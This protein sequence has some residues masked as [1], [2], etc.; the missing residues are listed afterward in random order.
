[1]D[2]RAAEITS[3]LKDQ[4]K[5]F[6][7]EAE[8]SEIGQVLSVGDGIARVYGLE[9]VMAGEL[10]EFPGQ[11]YGLVL[12][13][14]QDNVGVAVLG[15]A[16]AVKE[17]DTVKRTGRIAEVPVGDAVA[18]RV[19]NALCARERGEITAQ[20][21][22]ASRLNAAQTSALKASLKSSFGK[23]VRIDANVD[24]SLLGGLIVKVG[25]RMIDT[26]LRTRLNNLKFAMKEVG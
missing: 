23:D 17:G 7:K 15:D 26:S 8:V 6:G 2:I 20:V 14:E 22:S 16:T 1:M 19:V 12:N 21:T 18:G 5:N 4:I 24:E 9:G 11:V 3:I 10:V 25:S 13:L